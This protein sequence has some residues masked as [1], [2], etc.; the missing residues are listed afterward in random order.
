MSC[1]PEGTI[2]VVTVDRQ[3]HFFK[4]GYWL[5]DGAWLPSGWG[6]MGIKVLPRDRQGRPIRRKN[7]DPARTSETVAVG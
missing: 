2:H 5:K 7:A 4:D 3:S 6:L 1:E